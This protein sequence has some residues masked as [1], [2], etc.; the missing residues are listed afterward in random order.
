[1]DGNES[2]RQKPWP[3]WLN[4]RIT[5]RSSELDPATSRSQRKGARRER[6]Q[7]R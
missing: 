7:T 3:V 1:M 6:E 2:I 5:L 4:D